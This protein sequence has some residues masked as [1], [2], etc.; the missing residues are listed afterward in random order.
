MMLRFCCSKTAGHETTNRDTNTRTLEEGKE[1]SVVELLLEAKGQNVD[2]RGSETVTITSVT[3]KKVSRG[4]GDFTSPNDH[5]YDYDHDDYHNHDS[6]YRRTNPTPTKQS[7]VRANLVLEELVLE[8]LLACTSTNAV[9]K[10]AV[11]LRA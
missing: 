1:D 8:S 3:K 4:K 6:G 11:H 9:K 2:L 7:P 10:V 5:D